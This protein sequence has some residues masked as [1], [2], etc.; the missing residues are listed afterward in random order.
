[1]LNIAIDIDQRQLRQDHDNFEDCFY[2][3]PSFVAVFDVLHDTTIS[4]KTSNKKLKK[5]T[6]WS[7]YEQSPELFE[8]LRSSV[9]DDMLQNPAFLTPFQKLVRESKVKVR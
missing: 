6:I 7:G 9:N 2:T 1:M 3:L 8:A 4:S 5:V